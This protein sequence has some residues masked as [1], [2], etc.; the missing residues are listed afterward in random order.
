MRCLVIDDEPVARLEV[1]MLLEHL[2]RVDQAPDA[3]NGVTM[4]R[5]AMESNDPYAI[6][7]LDLSMPGD[8]GLDTL[9]EI[10]DLD[11]SHGWHPTQVLMVTSSDATMDVIEAFR[12][13][14]DGYLV[15]PVTADKL[16]LAISRLRL[17]GATQ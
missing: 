15:K 14:A 9:N 13:Q 6:V 7:C 4:I 5:E 10:R 11:E 16:E 2:G 17:P 3:E 8:D 1:T 12:R